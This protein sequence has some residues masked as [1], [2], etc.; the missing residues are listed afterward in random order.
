M[1]TGSLYGEDYI[2]DDDIRELFKDEISRGHAYSGSRL[3][4]EDTHQ[5]EAIWPCGGYPR[6]SYG[7]G[8]YKVGKAPV[9]E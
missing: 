5:C 3:Y 6:I 7:D 9:A 1:M 2:E 8:N 4:R